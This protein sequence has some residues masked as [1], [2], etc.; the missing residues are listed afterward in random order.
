MSSELN[1]EN[2]NPDEPFDENYVNNNYVTIPDW[3]MAIIEER[4][5][6]YQ[7]EDKT[8]WTTLEEFEKELF[9]EDEG[10]LKD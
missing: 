7:F 3:H 10:E 9:A 8:Q 4:M 5:A 2:P 1:Q 6:R